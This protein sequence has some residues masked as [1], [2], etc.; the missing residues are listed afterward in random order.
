MMINLRS[1]INELSIEFGYSLD[2]R[3]AFHDGI[4]KHDIRFSG[5]ETQNSF[6]LRLSRSWKSTEISF[7]PDPFSRDVMSYICG[8]IREKSSQV[9]VLI[10]Q[11]HQELS[12]FSLKINGQ[13]W[14]LPSNDKIRNEDLWFQAEVLTNESSIDHGLLNNEEAFLIS[15]AIRLFAALL[16]PEKDAFRSA[17]EVLGFPEGAVTT[18]VVNKYERDPRNRKL[19]LEIHGLICIGCGFDFHKF[20]GEVGQNFIIVHHTTPVS[21]LGDEYVLNPETDLIP[22]CA[23]CH[24]MIHRQNPPFTVQQLRT[25]IKEKRLIL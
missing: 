6:S 24:A 9:S 1:Y 16:P 3:S 5:I 21:Q 20:Y 17:D 18:V 10:D 8:E 22:L 7:V 12:H 25:I 19:A 11:S 4:Q 14:T 23:N 15:F 2:L 13:D